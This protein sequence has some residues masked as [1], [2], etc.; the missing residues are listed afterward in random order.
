MTI[1]RVGEFYPTAS[2]KRHW[3]E[4]VDYNYRS[5]Q[6]ELRIFMR[7]PSR[8]EI[9][10][11]KSGESRFALAVE[12]DIIFFCYQFGQGPWGDCGFSIHLVPEAE[13]ILPEIPAESEHALL[14][15]LLIDAETGIL[16]V[17]RATSLSPK[18][19]QRLHRAILEQAAAPFPDD[20]HQQ[21]EKVYKHYTSAQLALDRA[22]VHCR[23]GE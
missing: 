6:H 3:P 14:T 22:R 7:T 5:G 20:Y 12:R 16:K 13:R 10:D 1:Y 18:F 23:G 2:G 9:A 8:Q 11:I 4:G 19:T 15:T 21:A 17:L